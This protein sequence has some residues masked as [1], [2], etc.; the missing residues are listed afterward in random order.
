MLTQVSIQRYKSLFDVT[1]DLDPLT[2][3]IGPNGSGKSSVCEALVVTSHLL[4]NRLFDP[5]W[6]DNQEQHTYLH[7]I[8]IPAISLSAFDSSVKQ[9]LSKGQTAQSKFWQGD[10]SQYITISLREKSGE[11]ASGILIKGD[12]KVQTEDTHEK[13]FDRFHVTAGIFNAIK[14]VVLYDFT[15]ALIA[16]ISAD[17]FSTTGEGIA[18]ALTNIL[19]D[20]RVKFVE[21]E[22]RF[23]QLVPNISRIALKQQNGH[24]ALRLVDKYSDHYIPSHDISDGTL[25]I[26]AFLAALYDVGTPNIICFEEP[27]NGVHPWLLHKMMALLNTVAS[28]GISGQPVQILITTHSPVL[29]NYVKPEQVRVVELDDEGKTQIHPL[30]TTSPHLQAAMEAYE[31][32]VGELWFTNIFGGNPS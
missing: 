22:Q 3:F 15:P 8:D 7:D 27:E 17:S 26:L 25:R 16:N 2:I 18:H 23:V 4:T 11:W 12:D 1:I 5:N 14:R 24:P 21:L 10:T 31:N 9:S 6:K 20:D 19:F 32:Q 29:L 30:P 28:E 13:Q